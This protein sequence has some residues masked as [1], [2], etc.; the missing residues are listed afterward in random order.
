VCSNAGPADQKQHLF[1]VET[2]GSLVTQFECL[3]GIVGDHSL[4]RIGVL[5]YYQRLCR[6]ASIPPLHCILHCCILRLCPCCDRISSR[7][8]PF[9]VYILHSTTELYTSFSSEVRHMQLIAQVDPV[10]VNGSLMHCF[11]QTQAAELD[12]SSSETV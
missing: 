8:L 2:L 4:A 6:G 12:V 3:E 10:A 5:G 11:R 9:P 7:V 1:K